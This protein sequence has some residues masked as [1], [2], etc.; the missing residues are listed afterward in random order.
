MNSQNCLLFM[1]EKWKK[2]LD[3]KGRAGIVLTDLSKAFDCLNHDLLIA[4]L[5]AY[6]FSIDALKLVRSYL[7][8]RY[9]R[10]RI[11]GS[12]S[13]WIEVIFGVPQGSILGPIL[14]NIFLADLFS[15]PLETNMVNFAD[16]N[17][18]FSCSESTDSVIEQLEKDTKLI[19]SWFETNKLK[20]N[21][22]KFHFLLSDHLLDKSI[23]I[24]KVEIQNSECEKLLGI[25]IDS[26]LS[27]KEHVTTLCDKASNKLHALNR[28]A[29]FITVRQK[30]FV[31][32]LVTL[33]L[34]LKNY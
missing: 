7:T 27:F 6:G 33:C 31:L 20:A 18:P 16:D 34:P 13:Y 10:V 3:N 29:R 24:G 11:N 17:S 4:K 21:P 8:N 5:A 9:Q 1:I 14:F 25:K 30:L 23:K 32:S 19:L 15:L 28:V 26:K 2:C 12:Y 22:D